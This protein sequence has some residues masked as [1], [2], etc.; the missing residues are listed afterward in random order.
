MDVTLKFSMPDE[1]AELDNALRG[2]AAVGVL[3]ELDEALRS[4]LKYRDL[5]A[6]T[7]Q[8]L[9]NLRTLIHESGLLVY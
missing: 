2:T 3:G 1:K 7:S 5:D 8:L 4:A 6:E 9:Q